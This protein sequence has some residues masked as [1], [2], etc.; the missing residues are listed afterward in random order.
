MV[1]RIVPSTTDDDRAVVAEA[2][3]YEDAW[4]IMTE[5]FTQWVVE[6][7]FPQGRPPF[8]K[9]GAE[10]VSDVEP[11]E[12][13]KL[14]MLNGAHSTMAYLGYLS[15]FETIAETVGNPAL[16]TLIHDMM[17]D[18]V[19]PTLNINP[20][21]LKTYRDALLQRFANPALQHRTWQ[22]AMDGSQKLPQRLLDTIHDR[23]AGGHSI[24]RLSLGVA[25]WMRYAGG[26][27]EKGE[28]IDVRDPHAEKLHGLT[29]KAGG[30]P[31]AL[32]HAF[33]QLVEIFGGDLPTSAIFQQQLIAHMRQLLSDGALKTAEKV[34][35]G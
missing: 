23:L 21:E 17:T 34:A 4:P 9:V 16:R 30:D 27:D 13:M 3:G 31:E 28:K 22:I 33:L 20:D 2:L 14:R 32:V 29:V 24:E 19:I 26:N 15:G 10:L 7:N 6:D 5:P 35:A 11:F 12:R 8:E 1:D 18:E 25:A